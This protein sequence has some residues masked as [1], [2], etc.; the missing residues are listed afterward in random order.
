[1]AI[2]PRILLGRPMNPSVPLADKCTISRPPAPGTR[3][4]DPFPGRLRYDPSRAAIQD[5]YA[6]N[7]YFGESVVNAGEIIRI[8]L[9]IVQQAAVECHVAVYGFTAGGLVIPSGTLEDLLTP[10]MQYVQANHVSVFRF[11]GHFKLGITFRVDL[12][13]GEELAIQV[14]NT[15]SRSLLDGETLVYQAF[16]NCDPEYAIETGRKDNPIP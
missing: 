10:V 6:T 12:K 2:E 7:P 8:P 13:G 5:R 9:G 16:L 14:D 3:P 4:A 1:M 15:D 11:L